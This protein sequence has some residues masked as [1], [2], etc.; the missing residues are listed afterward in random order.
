MVP[1][2]LVGLGVPQ[3]LR[4]VAGDKTRSTL[5]ATMRSGPCWP[6]IVVNGPSGDGVVINYYLSDAP[7]DE[8]LTRPPISDAPVQAVH[9][10]ASGS[11]CP[12]GGAT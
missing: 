7:A 3:H 2:G 10:A 6:M 5:P 11:D 4:D 9:L 8:V 12:S 1:G